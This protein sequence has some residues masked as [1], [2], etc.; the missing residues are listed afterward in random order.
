MRISYIVVRQGIV[1][2]IVTECLFMLRK[3]QKQVF[4]QELRFNNGI[5]SELRWEID[6]DKSILTPFYELF[7]ELIAGHRERKEIIRYNISFLFD[8]I[9]LNL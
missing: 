2:I 9:H 7:G 5:F 4:L 8:S 3:N 1:K 6:I